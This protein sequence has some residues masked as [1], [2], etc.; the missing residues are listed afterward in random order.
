MAKESPLAL[1]TLQELGEQDHALSQ[2]FLGQ[3]YSE[4]KGVEKNEEEAFKWYKKAAE[5][6]DSGSA[7]EV[8]RRYKM[9]IGVKKDENEAQK[10]FVK[11]NML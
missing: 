9:G 4:G 5:N 8:G 10:W 11:S 3:L 2:Y 7:H 6:G 1:K